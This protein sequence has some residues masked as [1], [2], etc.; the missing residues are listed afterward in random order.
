MSE[1]VAVCP[2]AP[3]QGAP[4]KI[5]DKAFFDLQTKKRNYNFCAHD[6]NAA[7]EWIEKIQ[8]CLQ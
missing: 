4:K 2:S 5:D 6:G 1:V 7:Q 3:T 8:A